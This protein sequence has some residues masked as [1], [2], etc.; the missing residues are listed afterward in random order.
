MAKWFINYA[1]QLLL[2]HWSL[3]AFFSQILLRRSGWCA[4][5]VFCRA[6]GPTFSSSTSH[7]RTKASVAWCCFCKAWC[8][9]DWLVRKKCGSS[10]DITL[11][12]GFPIR[13]FWQSSKWIEMLTNEMLNKEI[14]CHMSTMMWHHA[15]NKKCHWTQSATASGTEFFH[16]PLLPMM[17]LKMTDKK[18]T[19]DY[20][21][22][23]S[24]DKVQW[25]HSVAVAH[26][27]F[28]VSQFVKS[29]HADLQMIVSKS[30]ACLFALNVFT[31]CCI[32]S[33]S[34]TVLI[35]VIVVICIALIFFLFHLNTLL[36]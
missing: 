2:S 24:F 16:L 21:Q 31:I 5:N 36:H 30:R 35:T 33:K 28:T 7:N 29:M 15:A 27:G 32:R 14:T 11:W 12:C 9:N 3:C 23:S 22:K 18:G 6:L 4:L 17:M 13:I 8:K 20:L 34:N 26:N 10:C 19:D 1:H 25:W